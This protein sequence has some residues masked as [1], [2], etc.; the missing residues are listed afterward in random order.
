MPPVRC[1]C[2]FTE[3]AGED[4]TTGDHFFEMFAP[5]DG[6]GQDGKVH[7]EGQAGLYCMCGAGGSAGKLDAHFAEVFTPADSVGPDGVIHQVAV[8]DGALVTVT[9]PAAD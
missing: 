2:G 6:I 8:D 5:D 9:V 3:D 7:L 1:T 4:Y